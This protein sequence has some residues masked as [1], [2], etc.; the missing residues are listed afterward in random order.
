MVMCVC[1]CVHECVSV[2]YIKLA[3]K[4]TGQFTVAF[5]PVGREATSVA[6]ERDRSGERLKAKEAGL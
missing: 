1:V 2:A 4:E 3:P 5:V 6:L